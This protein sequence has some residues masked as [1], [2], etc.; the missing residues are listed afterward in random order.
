MAESTR[1]LSY[2]D[3]MECTSHYVGYGHNKDQAAGLTADQENE[4]DELVQAGIAQVDV[5]PAVVID[6]RPHTHLWPHMRPVRSIIAWATTTGTNSGAPVYS[7]PS[8]TVTATASVFHPAMIS[9]NIVFDATE[10]SYPITS[11]T[12]GTVIVVTGDA[13][14]EGAADTFTITADGD[15]DL[16]DDVGG[17]TGSLTFA[18]TTGYVPVPIQGEMG[19]RDRRQPSTITGRPQYGAVRHKTSDMTDGQRLELMLWPTPDTD[20][21]LSYQSFLLPNKLDA[22]NKYP[23]GGMQLAEVYLASCL[24]M[25]EQRKYDERGLRWTAFMERLTAAIQLDGPRRWRRAAV[26]PCGN[27]Q[28]VAGYRLN[29]GDSSR[30]V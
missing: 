5:P 6:G 22:T 2:D 25:A 9:H 18:A 24:A 23:L 1:S 26:R 28:R 29:S 17:V 27:A 30:D 3:F 19:I 16:P 14:S 8:S 11:Y 10:N 21:T 7:S 20:Y 15:Y 12:S 4:I 13:S